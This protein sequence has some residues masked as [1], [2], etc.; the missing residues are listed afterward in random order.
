VLLMGVAMVVMVVPKIS[1][2]QPATATGTVGSHM[3]LGLHTTTSTCRAV[4]V[5]LA[6]LPAGATF[7]GSSGGSLLV[8][9]LAEALSELPR[10]SDERDQEQVDGI[11]RLAAV[12]QVGA[13]GGQEVP[14]VGR[15]K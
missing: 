11:T 5:S 1:A 4:K 15:A 10:L 2:P 7:G 14:L 13:R 3:V 8:H 12:L 9:A 6:A